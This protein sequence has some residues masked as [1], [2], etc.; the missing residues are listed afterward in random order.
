MIEYQYQM[1]FKQ[2]WHF[3]EILQA[4]ILG[5]KQPIWLLKY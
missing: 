2:S 1:K 5:R 4:L 3:K